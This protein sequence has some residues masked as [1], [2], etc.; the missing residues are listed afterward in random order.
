[1]ITAQGQWLR[2]VEPMLPTDDGKPL[3]CV[4]SYFVNEETTTQWRMNRS[5][6]NTNSSKKKKKKMNVYLKFFIIP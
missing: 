6:N 3:K 4:Q 2:R 5:V 1:M